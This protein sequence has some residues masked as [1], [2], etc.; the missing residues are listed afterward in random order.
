MGDVARCTY[1][2]RS[3]NVCDSL[4]SPKLIARGLGRCHIHAK[5]KQ[6]VQ[7]QHEGCTQYSAS[8]YGFCREHVKKVYADNQA[9]KRREA[10]IL[11]RQE[12]HTTDMRAL[13]HKSESDAEKAEQEMFDR[14]AAC[15]NA[16]AESL[17]RERSTEA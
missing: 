15:K 14:I 11:R 1:V 17:E 3:G 13:R 4:L 7:C 9:R 2:A 10:R 6:L 8:R 5:C 12:T 16:I